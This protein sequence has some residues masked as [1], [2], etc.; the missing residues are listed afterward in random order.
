MDTLTAMTA[1]RTAKHFDSSFKLDD[2]QID[3]LMDAALCA[4]SSYNI[5]HGRIVR[6]TDKGARAALRVAAYDQAQLTEASE[7]WVICG[8]TQAW[9][10]NPARYW[11]TADQETR[12]I[13]VGML[14]EFYKDKPVLERDEAIRSGSF[15][16]Q[17]IMVAATSLG[18][19]TGPMIGFD[20]DQVAEVINLPEDHVI[21]L[22]LVIGKSV[23]EP[24]ARGGQLSPDEVVLNDKF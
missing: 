3:C 15:M 23:K 1:R 13:L 12:D 8:D 6:V 18:L 9:R 2:Q 19:N 5:Q 4:P 17:N 11:R 7:V 10:K 22:I 20:A 24:W 21:A 16:A 14:T